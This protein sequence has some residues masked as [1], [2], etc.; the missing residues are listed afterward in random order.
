MEMSS[1]R[2]IRAIDPTR[3][4]AQ[5]RVQLSNSLNG[6]GPALTLAPITANSVPAE[7]SLVVSTSGSTGDAKEVGLSAAALLASAK[8]TNNFF[9]AN[10]GQIWSL[11]LPLTHIA[12]INVLVR[13]LELGTLPVDCR[14]I[15][16]A[17]PYA[18]FTAIVPTQLFRALN[19]DANLLEHLLSAKS[20]L[21][22]GAAIDSKLGDQARTAGINIVE[23]YGMTETCGGCVYDGMPIGDTSVEINDGGLIRISTSSLASIYLNDESSWKSKMVGGYFITSDL[24]EIVDGK[25]KVLGRA[26]DVI[27]SGGENI[28]LSKVESALN[29]TF[30]GIECAAFAVEDPHWGQALHLAIAGSIKPDE[31]AVNESLSKQVSAAA[32]VKGFI[33]LDKLPRAALDKIDRQQLARMLKSKGGAK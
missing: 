3:T 13:S 16:S 12:G 21:V 32:K 10:A 18:D 24:G 14:E 5:L 11:L 22:G 30:I 20:V 2:E 33:Y 4:L 15:N 31:S 8:A 17:Y 1:Q 29:Q 27:I 19:G 23:S 6:Q 26:D 7:I 25:L 9:S 28:S